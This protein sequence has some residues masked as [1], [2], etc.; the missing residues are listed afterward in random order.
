M[1]ILPYGA[2]LQYCNSRGRARRRHSLS[3]YNRVGRNVQADAEPKRVSESFNRKKDSDQTDRQTDRQTA[4]QTTYLP[5]TVWPAKVCYPYDVRQFTSC[6]TNNASRRASQRGH[7]IWI[8]W[9]TQNLHADRDRQRIVIHHN[10]RHHH[11]R[12]KHTPPSG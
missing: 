1:G 11:H 8:L 7:G 10:R 5:T 4:R 3:L 2:I 9:Q 12:H 6:W